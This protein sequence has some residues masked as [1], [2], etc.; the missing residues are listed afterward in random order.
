MAFD[1]FLKLDGVTGESTDSAFS[2]AIEIYSFS[3]GASN[4]VTIGSASTGSGAGKVSLSSFNFMKKLDNAS[5][6]LLKNCCIGDHFATGTLSLRKAGGEQSVYLEYDMTEVYI[7][8][9]QVSGSSGGDDTPTES[10]S[11]TFA[12]I[13]MKYTPQLAGGGM[14][15]QVPA[16]WNVTTNKPT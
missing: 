7:E 8:S 15:T 11:V 1:A 10:I 2:G 5:P 3:W 9:Y 4:P 12:Q 13:I 16:G 6:T 14:G